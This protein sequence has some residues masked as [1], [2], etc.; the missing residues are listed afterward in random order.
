MG[1]ERGGGE[2]T[3]LA[4]TILLVIRLDIDTMADSSLNNAIVAYLRSQSAG[5]SVDKFTQ[6]ANLI[7]ERA[8]LTKEQLASSPAP[9][10]EAVW[11]VFLPTQSKMA[12]ASSSSATRSASAA[13]A[14]GNNG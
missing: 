4:S 1:R 11:N 2:V 14:G 12:Q 7:Q 6:A 3:S 8:S 10:L 13:P 9:G 5:S